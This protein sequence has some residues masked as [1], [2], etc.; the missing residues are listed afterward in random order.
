MFTRTSAEDYARDGIYM[1][2]VDTG[3]IT[4]ENPGE[5]R[6]RVEA[7]GFVPP[8]DIVDGA[9]RVLD[10]IYRGVAGAPAAGV[11]FK[12]YEPVAW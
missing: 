11:L 3:W 6:A 5:R 2:S 10:P 9:A 7:R 12:D 4:Q 1:S 8:L